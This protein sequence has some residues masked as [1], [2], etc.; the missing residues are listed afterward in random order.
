M[1][2]MVHNI[3][4][5]KWVSL[6]EQYGERRNELCVR[7]L[8][9]QNKTKQKRTTLV[10]FKIDYS[11]EHICLVLP[12]DSDTRNAHSQQPNDTAWTIFLL[13]LFLKK[14][15]AKQFQ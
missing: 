12:I 9:K 11:L 14:L 4:Q 6:Q 13:L 2:Q 15:N 5:H 8:T 7:H 1:E 3:Q 10:N